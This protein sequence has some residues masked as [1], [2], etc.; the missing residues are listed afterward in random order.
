M[1]NILDVTPKSLQ[2][3]LYPQVRAILDAPD[4][5]PARLLLNQTLQAYETRAPKAMTVLEAGFD[6][7]TA[8][9]VLPELYR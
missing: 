3:E 4:M 9:L 7:A 8:V 2:E 1:R 6:D 5:D